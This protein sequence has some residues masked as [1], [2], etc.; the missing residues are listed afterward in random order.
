MPELPEVETVV[1]A[2]RPVLVG[3][4]ITAVRVTA[5]PRSMELTKVASGKSFARMLTGQRV[6]EI[7]RRGKNILIRLESELILWVHL[8][9][10]GQFR[11]LPPSAPAD[12]HDLFV[13]TLSST[14]TDQLELR[15]NDYRRFG[16]WRLLTDAE[17]RVHPSFCTLGPE[18]LEISS[19]DFLHRAQKST[20]QI[21]AALLN[22]SFLAGVGNIYADESLW[23][24]GIHPLRPTTKIP[25]EALKELLTQLKRLLRRS[26][27]L[28]GTTVDSYRGVNG[29]TGTFQRYLNVYGREGEPCPRCG[30]NIR[31]ITIGSRSA[32]FCPRCQ[33]PPQTAR[34]RRAP[35]ARS[36]KSSRSG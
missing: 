13:L 6:T 1:R 14:A 9:M 31:R 10:T 19:D 17:L 30:A 26:I 35:V 36:K 12:P 7:S 28:A 4:T 33:R 24:A 2:L 25:S 23:A 16:R 29:Q 32:H 20:R 11:H 34:V 8:K 15:F 3:Q 22:Q 21:K 5:P 18:P 27:R